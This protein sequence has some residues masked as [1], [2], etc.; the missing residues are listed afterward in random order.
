M[1]Y[2]KN[3]IERCHER[4]ENPLRQRRTSIKPAIYNKGIPYEYTVYYARGQAV[5]L[6]ALE[7]ANISFMPIGRA[8]ENDRGPRVLGGE[9]YKRYSKRQ[10]TGSWEPRRWRESWGIQVYTGIPSE[11][12]GAQWHDINFKF[13]AICAAPDAAFTCIEALVDAVVNPLLTMTKSGGLRF[14]FRI[15][16]Y[17]HPKAEEARSYIYKHMPNKRTVYLEI[18]GEEGYNR[19]DA[20]YEILMGN[21]LDPPIIS[22]DIFFAPIDILRDALHE[23]E[24]S[25]EKGQVTTSHKGKG[26]ETDTTAPLSLGSHRLDLA[27]EAFVRRG[28]LYLQQN[29]EY[30][31][32]TLAG[33]EDINKHVLL[34]ERDG[35]VWIRA[36]N[37][38]FDLP[39][40]A[41]PITDVW[42]D[43][44][45]LMSPSPKGLLLSDVFLAVQQG[46]L[47]PLAIKRSAPVLRGQED[48]PK[49]H[50]TIKKDV[51]QR[52][53]FLK[54]NARILALITETGL[55]KNIEIKSY[56][57]DGSTMCFNV[58]TI[59]QVEE[60]ER[61]LQDHNIPSYTRWK[62][63]MYLW[64]Q[65]KGI[66]INERMA[67]P[68]K[69][70]NVCEDPERCDALEKKGGDPRESI[71]S[72]CP[73]YTECQQHGFL[74]QPTKLKLAN[75]Q[76]LATPQ[77]FFNPLYGDMV[78]EILEQTDDTE[79]LCI[80]S[81]PKVHDLFFRCELSIETLKDWITNWQGEPLG[82]FANFLLN[83]LE[84]KGRF[85][86]DSVRRI[87][88]AVQAFQRQEEDIVRQMCQINVGCKVV[89]RSFVDPENEQ[90]LARFTIEF[91]GGVFA[92]IPLDSNATDTL[93][94][95]ELSFFTLQSFVINEDMKIPMS[96]GQALQ[97]G[98]LN[99]ETVESIQNFPIVCP[100]P[101]WTVW[102]QLKCFF[103]HYTRD[104]DARVR[105]DKKVLEF[106]VPPMLHPSVKRLLLTTPTLH[107]E[108]LRRV[109]PD[110]TIEV[111]RVEPTLWK[112]GNKVFQIRTGI[113][114][115]ETIL[116]YNGNWDVLG[117]S[118]IG[119][120]FFAGI[121]AEIEKNI[122]VSH[123]V[124]TYVAAIK[125][126]SEIVDRK[127][128]YFLQ[129]SEDTNEWDTILEK[130]QV[131]W[132][133]GAPEPPQGRIWRQAQILFGND[134]NP[135]RY[136]KDMESGLYKDERLQDIYEQNTATL[137][138]ATV[139]CARLNQLTGKTVVMLAGLALP[140]ITDRSETHLFDWEDFEVAGGLDKLP[141]VIATRQRFE[142]DLA[143]LTAKTSRE[144]VEQVLGCSSRQANRFLQKL[145]GG[146]PLRVPFREQILSLLADGNK[147][148]AELVNAIEGNPEAVKNELKRLVDRGEIVRVKRGVYSSS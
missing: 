86:D 18:L 88:S 113:Y 91:E 65:V 131:I 129:H 123:A 120:R 146:A 20:R 71:C 11:R 112:K 47:S 100:Y 50:Q 139:N 118:E 3:L 8:P 80:V 15:P 4:H 142:T 43:T 121:L 95:K 122:S 25:I 79:R 126:L 84:L 96:T 109:F 103:E 61:R 124:I 66:P 1:N 119:Q 31:Q 143:N 93:K 53:S 101:N 76:I 45:I 130:T 41:T 106:W 77:M 108:H 52:Q 117:I 140:G 75:T 67:N 97:L 74:S 44:G 10:I 114:P 17:L 57:P 39:I 132:I 21:L 27:K 12:Y 92:Y 38:D 70:G 78:K 64:E 89:E 34:W 73:V 134:N 49:D 2:L 141:E 5:K 94:A 46:N 62:P 105:W 13:E 32:W 51:N 7:E 36:S 24:P 85:Y 9:W 72:Q 69:H 37:P 56:V 136:E 111:K 23:P 98:I 116:A 99:T 28:F 19:W 63:R 145:R 137:L 42:D 33:S 102:H 35:T 40:E 83:A 22:K 59:E 115:R 125:Q 104:E 26:K 6:H 138:R 90:E 54:G 16:D 82:N 60:V 68:F 48:A 30:H 110:E 144:K 29:N 128:V 135:L 107:E 133:V 14:S 147:K 55:E 58:P 127:N 148:T 81:E 87:R